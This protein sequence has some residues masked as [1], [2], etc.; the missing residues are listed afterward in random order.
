MKRF[1]VLLCF[2]IGLWIFKPFIAESA[3]I[4]E[5]LNKSQSVYWFDFSMF[6]GIN[7]EPYKNEFSFTPRLR[8][9]GSLFS[10]S[11]LYRQA[12]SVG[13]ILGL[14]QL[15]DIQV[16]AYFEWLS[17]SWGLHSSIEI[18]YSA[19][20]V[21]T[22]LIVGW[23]L[24]SFDLNIQFSSTDVRLGFSCSFRLPVSLFLLGAWKKAL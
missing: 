15:R 8:I 16:G 20:S 11:L 12:F 5:R 2:C 14:H 18:G 3:T 19:S 10:S 21:F 23:S 13:L 24:V 17:I 4:N 1:I 6:G 22:K 9:G 7:F